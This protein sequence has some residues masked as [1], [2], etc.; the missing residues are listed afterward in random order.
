MG[1]TGA[2]VRQNRSAANLGAKQPCAS[3]RPS[4]MDQNK[5]SSG[6]P[7][8]DQTARGN[9]EEADVKD[10]DIAYA[11]DENIE[12]LQ[13]A[14]KSGKHSSA[15]KLAASR[16]NFGPSPGY[17]PIPGATGNPEEPTDEH[18]PSGAQRD[19]ALKPNL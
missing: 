16:P 17:R 14:M 15:E 8:S 7:E 11:E 12:G 13:T 18:T 19:K 2:I 5:K 10:P 6:M 9:I 3:L 4:C 1:P